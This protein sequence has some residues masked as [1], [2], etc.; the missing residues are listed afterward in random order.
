MIFAHFK[1]ATNRVLA[2]R[3]FDGSTSS[4]SQNPT[5]PA[6]CSS[7]MGDERLSATQLAPGALIFS[8]QCSQVPRWTW[9]SLRSSTTSCQTVDVPGHGLRLVG[10]YDVNGI[11]SH[12]AGYL[13]ECGGR[14]PPAAALLA[15]ISLSSTGRRSGYL[16][17]KLITLDHGGS[18]RAVGGH[19]SVLSSIWVPFST[20]SWTGPAQ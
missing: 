12:T 9:L 5:S 10:A 11:L 3:R 2:P 16:L 4:K 6:C 13:R 15:S 18:V 17:G 20:W 19:I 7:D 14:L 8:P 1:P